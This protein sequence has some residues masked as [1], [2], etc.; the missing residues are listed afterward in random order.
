MSDEMP[1]E[2]LVQYD[3]GEDVPH[4][5]FEAGQAPSGR[6]VRGLIEGS[7]IRPD[8]F[9]AAK[10][11]VWLFHGNYY[12]GYPPEH[13]LYGKIVTGGMRAA[14]AYQHTIE[15]MTRYVDGGYTVRYVWEHEYRAFLV[16]QKSTGQGTSASRTLSSIVRTFQL[17]F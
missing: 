9:V 8:G 17:S 5:H 16:C 1:T 12:H 6:E 15:Q 11:E 2:L 13:Q 7:A 14:E 3:T 10:N 4:V